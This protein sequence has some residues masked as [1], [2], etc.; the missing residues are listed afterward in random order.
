M[1]LA[2]VDWAATLIEIVGPSFTFHVFWWPQQIH[3]EAVGYF[4]WDPLEYLIFPLAPLALTIIFRT[5]T[6]WWSPDR[7]WR[8][9]LNFL[10][11]CTSANPPY[12]PWSILLNRSIARPLLR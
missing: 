2:C 8:Q 11:G 12:K 5:A 9:K 3:F 4:M 7:F 10:G 6:I 1:R